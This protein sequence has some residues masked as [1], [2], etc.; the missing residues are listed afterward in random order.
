VF[1]SV[2]AGENWTA[3]NGGLTDPYL[4]ALAVDP[5]TPTTLYAGTNGGVFQSTDAGGSWTAINAG[6]TSFFVVSLALDPVTPTTVYAG[7]TGGGV[8]VLR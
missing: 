4:H 6:R 1:H 3:I 7:T 5:T 2:D 8:F